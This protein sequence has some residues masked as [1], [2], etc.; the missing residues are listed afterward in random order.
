MGIFAR[1]GDQ[2][3]S[4]MDHGGPD[5]IQGFDV[6][7][8]VQRP[9]LM[10]RG[11]GAPIHPFDSVHQGGYVLLGSF[12][13]IKLFI[14]NGTEQYLE[15]DSRVPLYFD[16]EMQ[17]L[18]QLEKGLVSMDF[19]EETF[20][21]AVLGTRV[22]YSRLPR[23]NITFNV[24][25]AV[26]D[27]QGKL[28]SE[29]N[30]VVRNGR[31]PAF[32]NVEPGLLDLGQA[33]GDVLP[34]GLGLFEADIKPTPGQPLPS[35]RRK[36]NGRFVLKECKMDAISLEASGG[37]SVVSTG[38]IGVAQELVSLSGGPAG[39]DDG[40]ADNLDRGDRAHGALD[41]FPTR[42]ARTTLPVH[43]IAA[44]ERTALVRGIINEGSRQIGGLLGLG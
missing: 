37:K 38:W 13:G 4:I 3:W 8:W 43:Q 2:V 41:T 28:R 18:F 36:P 19:L 30:G 33:L 40:L 31:A 11:F 32:D 15:F 17:F 23:L 35:F 12:T 6:D 29:L 20:G 9:D 25:T 24:N 16:G 42:E 44:Q 14:R 1:S 34:A 7:V 39:V 21:A 22:M 26:Y 10:S 27:S 5:P